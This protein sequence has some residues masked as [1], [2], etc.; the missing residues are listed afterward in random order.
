M[1]DNEIAI[2]LAGR[3]YIYKILK[4]VFGHEPNLQLLK[5]ITGK[6][7][8]EVMEIFL[9]EDQLISY[10]ELFAQIKQAIIDNEDLLERIKSEYVYLMLGPN[11]LPA[12]PWESVYINKERV[13]FQQSTL[14]VRQAYL[15]YQL[16]P[17]EYPHVADDHIA[18]E[19]DFMFRLG[20]LCQESFEKEDMQRLKKLLSDQKNFLGNHLLVW[21]ND[22]SIEIKE[23][24]T[25]YF[26]PQMA[27][28]TADILH[29]DHD[30]IKEL[31]SLI[32][33]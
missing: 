18:I 22:F 15:E 33:V 9:K 20:Q 1:Y 25:H 27:S 13:I 29:S 28:L 12:P 26:Y 19:L 31:L 30:V 32:N 16:L 8:E 6:F 3:S 24:Q 2:I 14:K 5:T 11:K 7:T 23:S 4:Q 21:I 17:A 10:N